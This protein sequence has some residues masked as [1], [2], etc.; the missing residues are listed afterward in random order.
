MRLSLIA[1]KKQKCPGNTRKLIEIFDPSESMLSHQHHRLISAWKPGDIWSSAPV[2]EL[3]ETVSCCVCSFI[4]FCCCL[5]GKSSQ[6]CCML[7]SLPLLGT[8]KPVCYSAR[9]VL[10]SVCLLLF[11]ELFLSTVLSLPRCFFWMY[12]RGAELY[13]GL[14]TGFRSL[15]LL[16]LM[17]FMPTI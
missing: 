6:R 10:A 1:T 17:H 12:L 15:T 16:R 8:L 5:L 2:F 3:W 13:S 4:V 7:L 11:K 9:G 14:R